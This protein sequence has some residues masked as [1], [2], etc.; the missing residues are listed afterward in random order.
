MLL[1]LL[2][3]SSLQAVSRSMIFSHNKE[4]TMWAIAGAKDFKNIL[5]GD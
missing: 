1:F 5:P 3:A 2:W 4:A